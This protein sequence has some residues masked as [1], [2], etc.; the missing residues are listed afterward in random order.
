MKH[1]VELSGD[2]TAVLRYEVAQHLNHY[3]LAELLEKEGPKATFVERFK[4]SSVQI[5][6]PGY[7]KVAESL[8]MMDFDKIASARASIE[9]VETEKSAQEELDNYEY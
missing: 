5:M 1:F 2:A 7:A 3:E 6:R 9:A 8:P 4:V